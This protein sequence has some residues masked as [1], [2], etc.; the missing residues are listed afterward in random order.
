VEAEVHY[1]KA[2]DVFPSIEGRVN[3]ALLHRALG[4][5]RDEVLKHLRE[6]VRI[7][8]GLVEQQ[9]DDGESDEEDEEEELK[10]QEIENGETAQHMLALIL[11]QSDDGGD[12][13]NEL[14]SLLGYQYRLATPILCYDAD[15][16]RLSP[17]T[18]TLSTGSELADVLDDALPMPLVA[19]LQKTFKPDSL[20]WSAHHYEHPSTGYFSYVYQLHEPPSNVVEQA[21]H[22]IYRQ[23][24][25]FRPALSEARLAEWWLHS[26]PHSSGHQLHFDTDEESLRDGRTQ[27]LCPIA[28]TVTY[29]E[30]EAGGPTVIIDQRLGDD[31]LGDRC[32][33]IG[34]KDNRLVVFDGNLLHGKIIQHNNPLPQ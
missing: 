8:T 9:K 15:A 1:R 18:S 29:L 4:R 33:L 2:I 17:S 28:S 5:Q 3:L 7:H 10:A 21:I 24:S 22:Q 32:S 14:L 26:R 11:S 27:A 19:Q 25:L 12:E 30:S 23:A 16:C 20:F 31:K 13:A 34:P 6:A